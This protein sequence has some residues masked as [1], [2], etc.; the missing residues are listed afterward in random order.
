ML[1][2]GYGGSPTGLVSEEGGARQHMCVGK[3]AW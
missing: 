1:A 3:I 2:H